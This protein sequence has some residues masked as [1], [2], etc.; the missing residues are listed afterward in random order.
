VNS[1]ARTVTTETRMTRFQVETFISSSSLLPTKSSSHRGKNMSLS[2][3]VLRLCC[4][5]R[6]RDARIG[7]Q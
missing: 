7:S 6:E 2:L 1:D 3:A 5:R 4:S